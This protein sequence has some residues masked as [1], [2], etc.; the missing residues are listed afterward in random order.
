MSQG[1]WG[2][3]APVTAQLRYRMLLRSW[4]MEKVGKN[5][6]GLTG[7]SPIAIHAFDVLGL[8]G[9]A[10]KFVREGKDV[11]VFKYRFNKPTTKAE[12][13]EAQDEAKEIRDRFLRDIEVS[14]RNARLVQVDETELWEAFRYAEFGDKSDRASNYDL[15]YTRYLEWVNSFDDCGASL[16]LIQ[17]TKEKWENYE[18]VDREGRKVQKG[19]PTG[20]FVPTGCPKIRSLVQ[21][22][23]EHFWTKERGF[24]LRVVNCRQNMG[25]AGEEYEGYD[26]PMLAQLVFPSSEESDWT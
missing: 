18:D 5:H 16:Q 14:K 13:A 1:V 23:I 8:E 21:A 11:R 9:T 24:W 6:F 10:E 4:G 22:N 25:I 26:F 2:D 15:L 19:R 20:E 17:K 12:K 7:P 3:A